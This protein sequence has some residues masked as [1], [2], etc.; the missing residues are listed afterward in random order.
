MSLKQLRAKDK[1]ERQEWEMRLGV[2][3]DNR[4]LA[5]INLI[6]RL[7]TNLDS[8]T[9]ERMKEFWKGQLRKSMAALLEL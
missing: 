3:L 4:R 8:A 6:E 5:L 1:L 2:L 9:N 7:Q